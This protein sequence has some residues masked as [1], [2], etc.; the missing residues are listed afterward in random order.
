MQRVAIETADLQRIIFDRLIPAI[1]DEEYKNQVFSLLTLYLM[2]QKP[3]FSNEW[4]EDSV[5][6]VTE[7]VMM[8][9]M[10]PKGKAN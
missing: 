7:Y 2:L 9:L 6:R 8:L 5:R 4:L 10:D 1:E 3:D